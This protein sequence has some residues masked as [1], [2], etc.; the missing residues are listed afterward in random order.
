MAAADQPARV[1]RIGLLL[2][3]VAMGMVIGGFLAGGFSNSSGASTAQAIGPDVGDIRV[4]ASP[5]GPT[6]KVEGVGVGFAHSEAGAV[7]A[8]TNL[9]L[10]LEQAG[11]T[12]RASAMRGYG[13][14]AARASKE[15][16][17][18]EM[19]A[20]WDALHG[21]ITTNGPVKSSLFLRTVP[22]GHEISRYSDERATVEV[23]TLT[24][25]AAAGMREPLATWETASVEVVWEDEDWKIWSAQSAAGPSPAWAEVPATATD[26]FL[27]TVNQLEGYRYVAS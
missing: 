5:A 13:T 12:D 15:T 10:T 9:I 14:L 17:T 7:A 4:A 3:A 6:S 20:S 1:W 8:A 24:I 11:T 27:T 23:W 19:G 25:V 26:P 2:A 22:V 16:L 21:G 18:A